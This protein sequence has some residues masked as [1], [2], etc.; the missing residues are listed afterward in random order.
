VVRLAVVVAL[1][2]CDAVFGVKPPG[3]LDAQ[4]IDGRA[5]DAP[6]LHDED[7][8][9]VVDMLDN[10][11]NVPNPDQGDL[12][13]DGVGDVCDPHPTVAGD[14]I[15]LFDPFVRA[16]RP[17]WKPVVNAAGKWQERPDQDSLSQGDST[18]ANSL[19]FYD[20]GAPLVNPAVVITFQQK[21]QVQS[22]ANAGAFIA[23]AFP[24][25]GG[26]PGAYCFDSVAP[27][28]V[29]IVD[30]RT[31]TGVATTLQPGGGDPITIL[32]AA[33]STESNRADGTAFC[34]ESRTG[35]S[36]A[37]YVFPTL[38]SPIANGYVGLYSFGASVVFDSVLIIDH[39]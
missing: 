2:G 5:I 37:S 27:P 28:R 1:V 38:T 16:P 18:A 22:S 13:G 33:S 12:D 39:P 17:E 24:N 30:S 23:F 26:T 6:A 8:D 4:P 3:T 21:V 32:L 14:R 34:Y 19:S 25:G 11:P 10:C 29:E 15:V 20:L 36:P 31:G 9:G 7:H 35:A